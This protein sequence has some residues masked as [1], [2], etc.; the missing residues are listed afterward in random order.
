MNARARFA[1]LLVASLAT[2]IAANF[3]LGPS[4]ATMAAIRPAAESWAPLG[5]RVPN[6][7]SADTVWQSRAPR[8]A[9]PKVEEAAPPPPPPPVP[10]GI[11]GSGRTRQAIFLV[12][13]TG[14][15]RGGIGAALPDGGRILAISGMMVN[16]VDGAGKRHSRRMFVDPV[17]LPE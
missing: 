14:D 17:Q 11:V 5:M 1:T 13:G 12:G 8:G 2:G 9:A 10:V 6:L 3:L 16:W 7:A 4:P 15:F